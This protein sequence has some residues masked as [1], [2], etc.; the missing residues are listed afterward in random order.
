MNLGV[1]SL[2]FVLVA[3][4]LGFVKKMNTGLIAMGVA[5]IIGRIGGISDKDIIAGFNTS[6]FVMLLGVTYIFSISNCN[7]TLELFAKKAVALAGKRSKLIPIVLYILGVFLAAIGP[8]SIPVMALMA[9]FSMALAA[10]MKI[11][12]LMLTPIAVSGAAAGGLS[13]IAPSGII[14]IELAAKS[15]FTDI[16]IP[17]FFNSLLSY[18]LFC[19]VMYFFFKAY[20]I[21]A[22]APLK[23]D[24]LPKFNREQ[25][26]TLA[27]IAVMVVLVIFFKINIGLMAFLTAG[28]LTFLRVADEKQAVFGIP[29]GILI[30]VAGVNVLM[31]V[32]IKLQGIKMMATFLG[33]LMNESTATPILALTSGIMTFFSST[34]GVV[35]PTMIPTVNDILTTLGNPQNITATEMISAL[36]ITSQNAGMS[37]LSTAGALI[38]A[39]YGSTFNPSPKEEHKLFITLFAI[40]AAG[41][42]F[43]VVAS[44][45]GLFKIFN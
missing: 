41:L 35:M 17:F 37:P 12:P 18:T 38:M 3:I 6:L 19:I 26:I 5:L 42:L 13:P 32:V 43:M 22:D 21:E 9:M 44:Y 16:G 29:W 7:G 4:V 33:S 15:G 23:M 1:L 11:N 20:K 8:G 27:G 14:G 10:Q 25:I 31:D 36:S 24:D 34:S 30:M 40:S 45:F 39:A 2:L 28:V